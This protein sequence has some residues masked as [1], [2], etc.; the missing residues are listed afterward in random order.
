M[1][2]RC[3]RDKLNGARGVRVRGACAAIGSQHPTLG[4]L[5]QKRRETNQREYRDKKIALHSLNLPQC[6]DQS[7]SLRRAN[8][9]LPLDLNWLRDKASQPSPECE[10]YNGCGSNCLQHRQ[11][12]SNAQRG[13]MKS[14]TI[15][16]TALIWAASLSAS[17]LR[18]QGTGSAGGHA[19]DGTCKQAESSSP[20]QEPQL[21]KGTADKKAD[22][23]PKDPCA[24]QSETESKG[25]QTSRMLWIV[26][27]FAAVSANTKLPSLSAKSKFWLATE[28]SFDYSAF[29]WTGIIAGQEFGLKN[30]PEFGQGMA[31]Y[32]RYYWHNFVDGVSGTYF[33]EAIVPWVTSRGSPL[34]HVGAWKRPSPH[35]LCFISRGAH[36]D[37][38]RRH[39]L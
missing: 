30:Y 37:R 31:G 25:K 20:S 38:F 19:T 6:V 24:P 12:A 22:G 3:R 5:R 32:G 4:H 11:P 28:D 1:E 36:Q 8:S 10:G 16:A 33:T 2:P 34:L 17:S 18:A 29:V 7:Y 15:I 35:V 14:V 39:N 9:T 26:P 13:N 23:T 21:D 27:N